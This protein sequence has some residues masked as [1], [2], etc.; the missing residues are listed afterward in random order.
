MIRAAHKFA[1]PINL[2]LTNKCHLIVLSHDSYEHVSL[3]YVMS[4]TERGQV[5]PE[6]IPA[7]W[8]FCG[9]QARGHI[10]GIRMEAVEVFCYPWLGRLPSTR[11]RPLCKRPD[12]AAVLLPRLIQKLKQP[13]YVIRTHA[14]EYN[15]CLVK[16]VIL[17]MKS[18]VFL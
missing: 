12:V 2:A 11:R 17:D 3:S 13:P 9:M 14:S 8:C 16:G 7:N 5:R 18:S 10:G 6:R 15:S 1:R 4:S